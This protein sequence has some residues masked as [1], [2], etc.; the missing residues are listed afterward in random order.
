VKSTAIITNML[1][2]IQLTVHHI[3]IQTAVHT[4]RQPHTRR[5]SEM[6]NHHPSAAV[7]DPGLSKQI[8]QKK[9][10]SSRHPGSAST[11]E[12]SYF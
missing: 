9:S 2:N 7:T 6:L 3:S 5:T 1:T 12:H 8:A 4:H 10:G 11:L